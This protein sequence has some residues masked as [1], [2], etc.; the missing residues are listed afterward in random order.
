MKALMKSKS[1]V[2]QPNN[3]KLSQK[4]Q[5]ATKSRVSGSFS[6]SGNQNLG[7]TTSFASIPENKGLQD[8][9]FKRLES[10][11][12]KYRLQ[13]IAKKYHP[14]SRLS[15]CMCNI[16][17]DKDNVELH[18]HEKD[19]HAHYRNV[20][21][22]D[23]VWK[24]PV[25]SSR[26][27]SRR[28][29]EIRQAYSYAVDTLGFRAVMVTYTMSHSEFD[30]LQKNLDD[31][32]DAR[33]KMR[34]GRKWQKFRADYG[35][36]GSISALEVT[37]SLWN[38]WHTHV[39]EIMFLDPKNSSLDLS[40]D[41]NALDKW[42]DADLSQWWIDSLAKVKR[43]ASLKRGIGV[44][45]SSKY[46]AEYIAKFGKLPEREHWDV[47]MEVAKSNH[48]KDSKGLHPFTV[49][50]RSDNPSV[51][52]PDRKRYR[53]M[54]HEY[55]DAFHGRK[56]IFWKAGL[57]DLLLVD[58]VEEDSDI[59]EEGKSIIAISRDAWRA[60]RYLNKQA[61]VLNK[62]ILCRGNIKYIE[63]YVRKIIADANLMHESSLDRT[64]KP[65]IYR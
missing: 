13:R 5:T 60:I 15:A 61:D 26:I 62:T 21:R 46:T 58:V 55:A 49:L 19:R 14:N 45:S 8:S 4:T 22:C 20:M 42:L 53:A 11:T 28:A 40:V 65:P 31:L 27:T 24:C 64:T 2:H 41:D 38:G 36:I 25:C 16:S 30:P 18:Y 17:P 57:K 37:V 34:S 50:D 59:E 29:E 3:T 7:T 35:Y 43:S 47:A 51:S 52:E 23:N 6:R 56:Q 9:L 12:E 32:R 33:R 44:T 39:H 1:T 63:H 54:W 10:T 48:K